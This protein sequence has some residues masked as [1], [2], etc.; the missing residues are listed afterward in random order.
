LRPI[1]NLPESAVDAYTELNARLGC[2]VT[3][4]LELAVAGSDITDP[5][6]QEFVNPSLPRHEIRR[7]VYVSA[8][9]KS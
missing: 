3:N 9:W 5:D 7:S 4:S 6:H 2:R 1:G 8:V